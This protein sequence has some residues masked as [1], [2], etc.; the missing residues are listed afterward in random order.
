MWLRRVQRGCSRWQRSGGPRHEAILSASVPTS[1]LSRSP[2][3]W[4]FSTESRLSSVL[5]GRNRMQRIRDRYR[6]LLSEEVGLVSHKPLGRGLN[7]ALAYANTYYI[8]M[9]NLGFQ[10]VYQLFNSHTG[11]TCER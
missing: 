1:W 11:V 10:S 7:V 4:M 8:G 5:E 2:S 6:K 3:C 9:S